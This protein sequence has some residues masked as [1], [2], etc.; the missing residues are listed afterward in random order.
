M[1]KTTST[2]LK[3]MG[4]WPS[5]RSRWLD[6]GQVSFACLWTE[7][8]SRSLNTKKKKNEA[9]IQSSWPNKLKMA[10]GE[11]FLRDTAGSPERQDSSISPARLANHSE[12]FG[13]SFP[14]TE[15]VI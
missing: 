12:G 13:S 3:Y 15:L 10:L 9:N 7:T 1:W 5:V 8:E 4:Y 14:F 6:I 2:L 11:N